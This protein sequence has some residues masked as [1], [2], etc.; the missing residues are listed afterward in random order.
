MP[1]QSGLLIAT[2]PNLG[3]RSGFHSRPLPAGSGIPHASKH[4]LLQAAS[5]RRGGTSGVAFSKNELPPGESPAGGRIPATSPLRGEADQPERLRGTPRSLRFRAA[6]GPPYPAGYRWLARHRVGSILARAHRA[7]RSRGWNDER[8]MFFRR[9]EVR[10][11]SAR[12]ACCL[13][14]RH[15]EDGREKIARHP[16]TADRHG[17][18][19]TKPTTCGR[20]CEDSR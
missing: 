12:R 5:K 7:S 10:R 4:P 16:S 6:S 8:D 15:R 20:G 14:H 11:P 17:E 2:P 19:K 9:F 18:S 1:S 3:V 13:R